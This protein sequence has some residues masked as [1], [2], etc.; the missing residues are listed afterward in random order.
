MRLSSL[1]KSAVLDNNGNY[2]DVDGLKKLVLQKRND[3]YAQKSAAVKLS[4]K[5]NKL[6][7]EANICLLEEQQPNQ[8]EGPMSRQI[9]S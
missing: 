1:Q 7:D 9:R 4:A 8:D 6:T 5:L 3:Y 2:R